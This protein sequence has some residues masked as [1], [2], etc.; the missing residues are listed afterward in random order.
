[1]RYRLIRSERASIGLHFDMDGELIVRAPNH[2]STAE[3]ERVIEQKQSWIAAAQARLY[4]QKKLHPV[5]EFKPGEVFYLLG[6]K[7]ILKYASALKI[8]AKSGTLHVPEKKPVQ[9]II[10]N[11]YKTQA[12]CYL[13]KRLDAL[14]KATAIPF[15]TFRLSGARSCWG[16]C[17][18]KNSINLTWRLIMA[19]PSA[20]DYVI[21]HELCH[22]LH[23][24]HSRAFWEK[25][26]RFCPDAHKQ[27]AWLRDH[28]GILRCFP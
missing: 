20:I 10:E 14:S 19:E 4:M 13:S 11:W 21:V 25:V 6:Q 16:S 9:P 2:V 18:P 15:R 1:M 3:I 17:G 27:R 5:H 8:E 22:I 12:R 28:Q 7:L 23:R 24:D 26:L